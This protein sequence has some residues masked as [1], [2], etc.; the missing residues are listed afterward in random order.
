MR[1]RKDFPQ[2]AL[3]DRAVIIREP[4]LTDILL[5]RKRWEIRSTATTVRGRIALIRSG[6]GL[7][8]GEAS[9]VDCKGPLDVGTLAN[10]SALTNE[11]RRWYRSARQLPYLRTFAWVF[12]DPLSYAAPV[13]YLH[14]Q[15]AVRFVDLTKPGIL[16]S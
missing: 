12:A 14:P 1:F 15:G 11:E 10:S 3:P 16:K 9:I 8:V 7:I 2:K 5:G 6:S 4:F 13:A